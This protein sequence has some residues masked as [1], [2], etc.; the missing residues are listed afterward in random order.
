MSLSLSASCSFSGVSPFILRLT[1]EKRFVL[2]SFRPIRAFSV[3]P[4]MIGIQSLL[5]FNNFFSFCIPSLYNFLDKIWMKMNR[6]AFQ[7]F[8]DDTASHKSAGFVLNPHLSSRRPLSSSGI[9]SIKCC[10]NITGR[11]PQ[12]LDREL[13][14]LKP[15][16]TLF[17]MHRFRSQSQLTTKDFVAWCP[18]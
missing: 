9:S 4:L 3:I 2:L 10:G 13:W 7:Y 17:P 18:K 5:I 1:V 6:L 16:L 11:C 14:S 12:S 15:S 8:L